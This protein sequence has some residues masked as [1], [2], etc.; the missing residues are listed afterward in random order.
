MRSDL[1]LARGALAGEP[2]SLQAFEAVVQSLPFSPEVRQAVRERALVDGRLRDFEGRC[3]LRA[4]LKTVGARLAVDLT[5][6]V[7]EEAVEERV[8]D[9][10]LPPSAH[11]EAELVASESRALLT[12]GVRAALAAMTE[13]E[14]LWI[15]HHYLDG[16]TLSA[17]AQLY[18]V[19]PSTVMRALD[20]AV[21]EL[22]R[23]VKDHLRATHQ[24]GLTS[25]ESLVRA[26]VS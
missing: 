18:A 26:G 6:A 8:L 10:L 12:A 11:L 7:R 4:W 5:R 15:Q 13:R 19:A 20:K 16:M 22:R 3:P 24:L 2:E 9:A 14:R 1:E 23:L 21:A 17:I 25:L